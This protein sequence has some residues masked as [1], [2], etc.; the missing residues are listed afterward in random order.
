MPRIFGLIPLAA[1][2]AT[3]LTHVALAAPLDA[4]ACGKLV[5]QRDALEAR[6]VRQLV[7]SGPPQA[8]GQLTPDQISH[9][10]QLMDLDG[11]LRFRCPLDKPV[12]ALKEDPPEEQVD[13]TSDGVAAKAPLP[14]KQ[15]AKRAPTGQS[16]EAAKKAAKATPA[17][18]ADTAQEVPAAPKTAAVKATP[19]R[20]AVKADDAYK[21]A[22]A[23]GT[24][25]APKAP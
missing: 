8:R 9:V 20:S 13:G 19:K 18:A 7:T 12:A 24:E 2:L 22:P 17:P 6:G 15:K 1:L 21:P 4:E 11:Q 25:A 5:Q 3:G 14:A 16:G 23:S 10:R